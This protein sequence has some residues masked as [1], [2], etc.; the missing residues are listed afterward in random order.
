MTSQA[1]PV[2]S[3]RICVIGAGPAGLA[4]LKYLSQTSYFKKGSWSV[5][6]YESR[7]KVGGIWYALLINSFLPEG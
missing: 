3:K 5:V 4:V 1:N 6:A 2:P 7:P